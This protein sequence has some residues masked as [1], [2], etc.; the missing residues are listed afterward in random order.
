MLNEKILITVNKTTSQLL[1]PCMHRFAHR[2][3]VGGTVTGS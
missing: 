1:W 2:R 3:P